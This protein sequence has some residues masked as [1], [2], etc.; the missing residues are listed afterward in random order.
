MNA[1]L[2]VAASVI[3]HPIAIIWSCW[4]HHNE[5]AIETTMMRGSNGW[6]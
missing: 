5:D 4:G 3:I 2:R 1:A 6:G